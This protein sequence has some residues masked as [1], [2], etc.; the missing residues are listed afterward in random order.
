[1]AAGPRQAQ[2][3][4]ERR[5]PG[6]T[7]LPGR[8]PARLRGLA[9]RPEQAPRRRL[10]RPVV[11]HPPGPPQRPSRPTLRPVQ[12]VRPRLAGKTR[13][14]AMPTPTPPKGWTP[15]AAR[16]RAAKTHPG[17]A[18]E[19]RG[20]VAAFYTDMCRP[21]L[22]VRS[23]PPAASSRRGQRDLR[24]R[25]L[26]GVHGRRRRF[27]EQDLGRTNGRRGGRCGGL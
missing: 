16:T 13:M 5:R 12:M 14:E 8:R 17:T 27:R 15:R 22:G 2:D 6:P 10:V 26:I 11:T 24:A 3:P 20:S 25:C 19:R 1:V 7:S 4:A 18:N 21:S 23:Q 9:Q